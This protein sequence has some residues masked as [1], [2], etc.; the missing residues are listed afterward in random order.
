MY[1]EYIFS[2]NN[3]ETCISGELISFKVI[4]VT[5]KHTCKYIKAACALESQPNNVDCTKYVCL[6]LPGFRST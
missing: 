5:P 1:I 2:Y 3:Q 4:Y 6:C